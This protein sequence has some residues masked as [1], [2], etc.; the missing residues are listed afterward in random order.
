[1]QDNAPCHTA[2]SVKTF[3]S[4]EDVTGMEWLAQSP[5]MNPIANV[6]KLLNERA[7]EKN[8]WSV[9]ELWT[10]LKEEG[11]KISVDECKTLIRSC[12]KWCQTIIE[13]KGLHIN[14]WW[15]MNAIFIWIW[16]IHYKCIICLIVLM[17]LIIYFFWMLYN[18]FNNFI[19]INLLNFIFWKRIIYLYILICP[20]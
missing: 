19:K 15:I 7:K 20:W 4:E 9:E 3:L 2:P 13:S 8:P 16:C 1:M 6:W 11:E 5:D 10:N 14:Y 17:F 18:Y 12:S